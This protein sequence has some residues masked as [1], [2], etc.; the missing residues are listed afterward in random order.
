MVY[1]Y[2]IMSPERTKPN[3]DTVIGRVEILRSDLLARGVDFLPG[4]RKA[5]F[6]I[7]PQET[8]SLY[9]RINEANLD[10]LFR[11]YHH[12]DTEEEIDFNVPTEGYIYTEERRFP[13]DGELVALRGV[14]WNKFILGI[15]YA[16]EGQVPIEIRISIGDEA[17]IHGEVYEEQG[18]PEYEGHDERGFNLNAMQLESLRTLIESFAKGKVNYV[19]TKEEENIRTMWYDP[20][21]GKSFFYDPSRGEF[22]TE[23]GKSRKDNDKDLEKPEPKQDLTSKIL[24]ESKLPEVTLAYTVSFISREQNPFIRKKPN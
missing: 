13:E 24:R 6:N 8:R 22:F 1:F 21:S 4:W 17:E 15:V 19:I 3:A 5:G 23:D 18:W 9:D 11:G 16:R 20:N 10:F 12:F 2:E 7:S 14:V